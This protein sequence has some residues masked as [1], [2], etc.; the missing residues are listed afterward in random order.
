MRI[1][2]PVIIITILVVAALIIHKRESKG[3][4][5]KRL[6]AENIR[7]KALLNDLDSTA[8]AEYAVTNS[9]FAWNVTDRIIDYKQKEIQ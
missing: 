2:I 8:R 9:T 3:A 7:L 1:F 4:Q 5:A 6:E